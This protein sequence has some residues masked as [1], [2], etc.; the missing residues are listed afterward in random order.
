MLTPR[1]EIQS[2][3]KQTTDLTKN[4]ESQLGGYHKEIHN[5]ISTAL[6]SKPLPANVSASSTPL[7]VSEDSV[8]QIAAS[9]VTEQKEKEKHHVR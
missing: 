8:A 7:Q 5:E 4:N 6:F 9:L 1:S 3:E 2:T